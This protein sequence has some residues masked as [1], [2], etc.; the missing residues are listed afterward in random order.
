MNQPYIQLQ[1]QY[2]Y[3]PQYIQQP[4]PSQNIQIYIQ[5]Q[6]IEEKNEKV[7]HHS[8][9]ALILFICGFL[10]S[11]FHLL[12]W[13]LFKNSKNEKAKKLSKLSIII[14]LIELLLAIVILVIYVIFY[15]MMIYLVYLEDNFYFESSEI[16]IE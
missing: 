9:I 8:I 3:P 14:F 4:N 6:T 16:S 5:P 7:K 2:S 15:F 10:S 11:F 1:T 13:C 12:N